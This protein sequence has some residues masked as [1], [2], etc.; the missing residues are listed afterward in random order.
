M[1]FRNYEDRQLGLG[2]L[3]AFI[4]GSLYSLYV[5]HLWPIL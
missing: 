5:R 1:W 2:N 4:Y 3:V